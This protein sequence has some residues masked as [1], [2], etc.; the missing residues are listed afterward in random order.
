MIQKIILSLLVLMVLVR[1]GGDAD[2]R[3]FSDC[4]PSF[5]QG[6][7][8]EVATLDLENFPKQNNSIMYTADLLLKINAD[9]V[10]LQEI[11][12]EGALKQ[13]V[14]LMEGWDYVITPEPGINCS[15]AFLFK[16]SEVEFVEEDIKALE[17]KSSDSF[18]QV[19]LQIKVRHRPSGIETYL[20]NIYQ[21]N[22][23]EPNDITR[24]NDASKQLKSIL[25][26]NYKSDYILV[27]GKFD[28]S[29]E[30]DIEKASLFGAF[31]TDSLNYRIVGNS[32]ERE[33]SILYS[34]VP[35]S[36]NME[37]IL[38]SNEWFNSFEGLV[39]ICADECYEDYKSTISNHR[40]VVAVFNP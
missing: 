26:R 20:I 37:S 30:S 10:A 36:N 8:F 5:E 15:Q 28:E 25:D 7:G 18:C 22:L 24:S 4:V 38:L 21:E 35:G 23:E 3:L 29:I 2:N 12:N 19:P 33:D 32:L 1:C 14:S 27:L 13:L 9:I 11:S 17:I 40:P 6:E 34:Y 16:I 31:V 39:T